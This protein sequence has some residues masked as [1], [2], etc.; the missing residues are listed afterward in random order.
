MVKA[1]KIQIAIVVFAFIFLNFAPAA[2]ALTA[3]E[4]L[5]TATAA[6]ATT[7]A[8]PA[9]TAKRD[10][11]G[12]QERLAGTATQTGLNSE[13]NIQRA[14]GVI[15]NVITGFLGLVFFILMLYGGI[16]WMTAAGDTKILDK[17]KGLLIDAVVGL[18]IVLISYQVVQFIIGNINIISTPSTEGEGAFTTTTEN[19][20][21]PAPTTDEGAFQTTSEPT[22]QR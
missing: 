14:V 17:A 12:L 6:T 3:G 9:A 22:V 20:A 11:A 7:P 15:I 13:M 16:M 8:A 18:G 2:E 4:H 10:A 1:R 5:P 21:P 19:G